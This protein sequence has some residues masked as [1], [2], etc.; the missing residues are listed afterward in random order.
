MKLEDNS[1]WDS[2]DQEKMHE[3]KGYCVEHSSQDNLMEVWDSI[4]S[5]FYHYSYN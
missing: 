2:R 4:T 3:N 5:I 1:V